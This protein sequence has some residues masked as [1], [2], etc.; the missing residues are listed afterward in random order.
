MSFP[1]H[2]EEVAGDVYRQGRHCSVL[3]WPQVAEQECSQLRAWNARSS[4]TSAGVPM[5]PPTPVSHEGAET[6]LRVNCAICL[7]QSETGWTPVARC[8]ST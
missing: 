3:G 7:L 8:G 6:N 2:R 5:P 4:L 1:K